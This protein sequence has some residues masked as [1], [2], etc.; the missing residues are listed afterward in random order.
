MA[1]VAVE[2]DDVVVDGVVEGAA[3]DVVG[4]TVVAGA[5]VGTALGTVERGAA[6]ATCPMTPCGLS[7]PEM[8]P[9][10]GSKETQPS[11]RP[12]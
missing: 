9:G 8:W 2:A 1:L 11:L 12:R 7:S 3:A 5:V 10:V 6:I 4:G